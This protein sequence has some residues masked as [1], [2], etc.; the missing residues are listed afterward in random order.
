[1]VNNHQIA[2]CRVDRRV[3]GAHDDRDRG[4]AATIFVIVAVA[5]AAATMSG[6]AHLGMGIRERIV[7][8]RLPMRSHWHLS[9]V[10]DRRRCA[11]R[12][13]NGSI[14][15]SWQSGPGPDEVTVVVQVDDE[16]A[17]ARATDRP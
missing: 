3:M 1:M 5:L 16:T 10:A 13:A 12:A 8:S 15:V 7:L 6:L 2:P 4:Q 9:T 11:S 14:L 17:T